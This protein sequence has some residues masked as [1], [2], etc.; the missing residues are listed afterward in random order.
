MSS[1][2]AT[3]RPNAV[4]FIA[5]EMLADSRSA[6]SAGFALA[7]AVNAWMRPMIVP[8]SPSRVAMLDASAT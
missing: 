8:S 2:M 3:I 6:F 7:T 1:G 4:V 5:T